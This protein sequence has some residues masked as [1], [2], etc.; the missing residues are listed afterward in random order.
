MLVCCRC[1]KLLTFWLK[2]KRK[3]FFKSTQVKMKTKFNIFNLHWIQK[4][5]TI[6]CLVQEHF[7]N[8]YSITLLIN[9]FKSNRIYKKNKSTKNFKRNCSYYIHWWGKI[10]CCLFD[11]RLSKC[12]LK[13]CS[14]F[15]F[16]CIF[17]LIHMH[18][19]QKETHIG[20]MLKIIME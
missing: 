12:T 13:C 16:F 18:S 2:G 3:R 4:S 15:F 5:R 10:I 9:I 6:Q 19:H 7:V 1:E 14:V 8:I 11:T 17:P 20:N